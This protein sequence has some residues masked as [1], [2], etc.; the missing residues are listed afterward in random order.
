MEGMEWV[1]VVAGLVLAEYLYFSVRT[2]LARGR[3]E[4]PAPA[5]AGHPVFER[6]YRVQAN[7]LEQLIVF[8]PALWLFA[9]YVSA[10]VASVLGLAFL[11]GRALYARGYVRDPARRG[12]GFLIGSVATAILLLGG[13]VGALLGAL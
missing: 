3:Y 12:P 9:Y 5:M 7:T 8:L 4:V 10:P 1:A 2:G 6:T 13:L 11:V